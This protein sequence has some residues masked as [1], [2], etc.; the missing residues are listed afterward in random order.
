MLS[1]NLYFVSKQ[2]GMSSL[3]Y[4]SITHH[5]LNGLV[6]NAKRTHLAKILSRKMTY[7]IRDNDCL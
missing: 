1:C 6:C 5:L 4:R 2:Q 3:T 7:Q